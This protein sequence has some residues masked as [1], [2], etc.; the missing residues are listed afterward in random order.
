MFVYDVWQEY[1]AALK[2]GRKHYKSCVHEGKYPYLSTL[3][4]ILENAGFLNTAD[5]GLIDVPAELIVG[6]KT[7]GRTTGFAGNFM[8]ILGPD[9][10]FAHKWAN[11]CIAHLSEEGLRDPVKCYEYLGKF[12]V[13]EG[14]KRV[15]VLKHFGSPT[16]PARVERIVPAPSDEPEISVYYEFIEFYKRSRTYLFQFSKPGHYSKLQAALGFDQEHI[17]TDGELREIKSAFVFFRSA[18]AL[19]HPAQSLTVISYAFL[20]WLQLYSIEAIPA[21]SESELSAAIEGIWPQVLSIEQDEPITMSVK[22]PDAPVSILAR[23]SAK[24]HIQAA[25]IYEAPPEKSGWSSAHEEG[26]LYAGRMLGSAVTTRAYTLS[27][28][29]QAEAVIERAICD[30]AQIIFTTTAP[31]ITACRRIAAKHSGINILNCSVSMPYPGVRTYYSRIHEG[32]FV[33]GAIAGALC[34]DGTIGYVAS[35]PIFGVPASINAF[36]LGA[37][38]TNPDCRIRLIWSCAEEKPIER[39]LDQGITVISNRD[40][41]LRNQPM[42]QWGLCRLNSAGRLESVASPYWNWGV[43]YQ[44]VLT[45][46]LNGSWNALQPP[47]SGKTINFWWGMASDTVGVRLSDALPTGVHRL[48]EL[49]KADLKNGSIDPFRTRIT[50]QDG[51]LKNDGSH[52]LGAEEIL[53]MDWL[54]DRVDGRIPQ[55]GELLPMSREIVRLLG[56]YRGWIPP[57]IG[58]I[59]L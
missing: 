2:A 21:M 59:L 37:M 35:N 5:L 10:E 43:F 29:E 6:T 46:I 55:Y 33:C 54:C 31:M 17:W 9:T 38:M 26:R 49:L 30:G 20:V 32:K 23:F 44:R 16:I 58:G 47:E 15:S 1:G 39:L 40:L 45:S 4:D 13:Q 25:F 8:P 27:S 56:V 28:L 41:P 24:S 19:H 42:E 11:L 22:E 14:N 18:L 7:E 36:A 53:A 50:A 34:A 57:E 3:D 48:A 51:S 52:S 12:Y